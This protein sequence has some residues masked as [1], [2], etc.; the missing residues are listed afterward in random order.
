VLEH[1]V[2]GFDAFGDQE[3]VVAGLGEVGEQLPH[4]GGGLEL[5][6]GAVEAGVVLVLSDADAQQVVVRVGLV[7]GDV[8]RRGRPRSW[9]S[10]NRPSRTA[11][12]MARPWSISSR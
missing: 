5:V 12:S 9:E 1:L 11:R 6:T 2:V 3:G 7:R 8:A 10:L 4:L